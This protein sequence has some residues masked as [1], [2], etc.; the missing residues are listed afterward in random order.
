MNTG[1]GNFRAA[2]FMDPGLR[3]DDEAPSR[4]D[5]S[6]SPVDRFNGHSARRR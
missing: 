2:V 1:R 4:C 6:H 3:R 5:S